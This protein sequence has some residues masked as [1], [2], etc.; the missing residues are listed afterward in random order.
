MRNL[1]IT[2]QKSFVACLAKMKIYIEDHTTCE[3]LINGIPCRKIG[4]LKNNETKTFQ[5]GDE[6]AKVFVIADTLSRNYSNEYFQLP[7]GQ[8]DISL[9]G[10]NKFNMASGNPFRFDNNTSADVLASRKKGARIGLIV[11]IVAAIV[12]FVGGYL[13]S[14]GLLF[15]SRTVEKDFSC[16]DMQITLTKAFKETE[17][18]GF[19]AVYESKDVA[20]FALEEAFTLAPNFGDYTL[21]Q[22]A[23]LV[24][25]SNGMSI[26][27]LKFDGDLMYFEYDATVAD[28]Q[29]DYHY[30]AYLFKE[31]DAFWM[32]QFATLKEDAD[33][34]ANQ[35]GSWAKTITFTEKIT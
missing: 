12:G 14:S 5:I 16:N 24:L 15:G 21:N 25:D 33:E 35:I 20:V 1:T 4:E 17:L 32:I 13:L 11:L 7:E 18:Q 10:K 2:R 3:L 31:D 9:S 27:D 19:T 22:Y 6:A 30:V 8:E 28:T 23:Q 29:E 26:S 34:Y